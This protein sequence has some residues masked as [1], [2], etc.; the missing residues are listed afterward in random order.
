MKNILNLDFVVY[1]VSQI[2]LGQSLALSFRAIQTL[3]NGQG[4]SFPGGL[5]PKSRTRK[6]QAR[7]PKKRWTGPW[8]TVSR[9]PYTE[10]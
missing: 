10:N 5:A 8:P 4:R 2:L 3:A 7:R 1:P 9:L 6:S